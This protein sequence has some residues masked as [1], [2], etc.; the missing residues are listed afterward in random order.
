MADAISSDSPSDE[1]ASVAG[2]CEPRVD[3]RGAAARRSAIGNIF[4][5]AEISTGGLGLQLLTGV[6]APSPLAPAEI[7]ASA[8][9]R[10]RQSALA[11]MSVSA[12]LF[13]LC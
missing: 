11:V 12:V 13:R 1:P 7:H 3:E 2:R 5:P 4:H 10:M 9:G 6:A 8:E